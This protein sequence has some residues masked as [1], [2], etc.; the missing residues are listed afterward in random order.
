LTGNLTHLS[1]KAG[2][3]ACFFECQQ[4]D[5]ILNTSTGGNGPVDDNMA[6]PGAPSFSQNAVTDLHT[7]ATIKFPIRF[8]T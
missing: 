5:R 4:Y 7:F 1:Q 2:F 8:L 6:K 3:E